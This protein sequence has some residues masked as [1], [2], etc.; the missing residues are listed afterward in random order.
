[1]RRIGT[2]AG[3]TLAIALL[4]GAAGLGIAAA[5]ETTDVPT[6][7]EVEQAEG[8]A[9]T[10]AGSV[11]EVQARL[12]VASSRLEAAAVT[13][14]RAAEAYNGARWRADQARKAADAAQVRSTEAAA[15]QEEL[16]DVYAD[17][18]VSG[19]QQTP[20]L[21][22][23]A[24]LTDADGIGSALETASTLRAGQ[25]ALDERYDELRA[26]T[27]LADIAADKAE[28]ART[29][30]DRAER[31]ARAARDAA[32]SAAA[33]ADAEAAAV[34]AE[35][36][37][38][39]ADLARLQHVSVSL[40]TRRQAGLEEQA[41]QAAAAAAERQARQQARQQARRAA[42]Q[43]AANQAAEAAAAQEADDTEDSDD[44]EPAEAPPVEEPADAPAPSAGVP[45][46]L[47]F[48]RAQLGEPYRWAASGPDAWDCSGLTAGAWAAAG[49]SLPHYSVAQ[50]E[51]STPI[52]SSDL[53]PGDLV[54]WGDSSSPSSIYHVALYAGDGKIIHAP[55]TGKP[56]TE[57]SMY[58]WIPPNFFAR[59]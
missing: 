19:Y 27:V 30:A 32:T 6:Q 10:A 37:R 34:A 49:K 22:A 8:A 46:V 20:Q 36:T 59:P 41:R 28:D 7:A 33:R 57:E 2:V 18:V 58:Y 40:A 50:Y 14:A 21:A 38:L 39:V 51:Q 31:D 4:T 24:A 53:R 15:A 29:E 42:A 3:L 35:K 23:L 17:L 9:R 56:V 47:A 1:M 25:T 48:A 13:A 45:A 12:A 5:D 16:R 52:S 26:G 43:A 55:R 11:A 44:T 54:F